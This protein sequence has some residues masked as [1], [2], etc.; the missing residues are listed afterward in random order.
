MKNLKW[1]LWILFGMALLAG[2]ARIHF[3]VEVLNLLPDKLP[4]VKGLKSYQEYFSNSRELILTLRGSDPEEVESATRALAKEFKDRRDLVKAVSW[5]PFW[6]QA[7]GEAG[8]LMGFLWL[9]QDPHDLAQMADRLSR[10]NLNN[11]LARTRDRLATSMSP[12]DM[13]VGAYDPFGL[14]EIPS[15]TQQAIPFASRSDDMFASED[16]TFRMMFV[17]SISPLTTYRDC[18]AWLKQMRYLVDQARAYG[19]IS[20]SVTIHYTGR[21]AFVTEIAGGMENDMGGSGVHGTLRGD[22]AAVLPHS[23]ARQ[24]ALMAVRLAFV[25]ACGDRGHRRSAFWHGECGQ[26][27]ICGHLDGTGGRFRDCFIRGNAIASRV[28]CPGNPSRSRPRNHLVGG[29]HGPADF[30]L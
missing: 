20:N 30:W 17:E 1:W 14:L 22:R 7:P 8:E 21:P 19:M 16:G 11:T 18:R 28:E 25:S 29:D 13:A 4:V 23:S 2:A 12:R 9:N 10:T 24:A 3:D 5:Q 27:R 6:M 26:S 15:L